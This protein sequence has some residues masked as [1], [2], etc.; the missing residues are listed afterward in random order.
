MSSVG[1]LQLPA[2]RDFLNPRR[3]YRSNNNWPAV[4]TLHANRTTLN[5][6]DAIRDAVSAVFYARLL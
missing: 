6:T 5:F 1:M 3:A 2:L 4:M